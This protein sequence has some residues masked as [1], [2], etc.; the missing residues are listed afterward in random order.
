VALFAKSESPRGRE[1]FA[2]MGETVKC[3][4]CGR[5]YPLNATLLGRI[6]QCR[7]CGQAFRI[8]P[9]VE[10]ETVKPELA[11]PPS[12][13]G[14]PPSVRETPSQRRG[15]PSHPGSKPTDQHA[16]KVEI[17]H[18][19][20]DEEEDEE[21]PSSVPVPSLIYADI[22]ALQSNWEAAVRQLNFRRPEDVANFLA[23]H[24]LMLAVI[25]V[26]FLSLII[27]TQLSEGV[28]GLV[29][30]VMG[31]A[32]APF[33]LLPVPQ[34]NES[35]SGFYVAFVAL[36]WMAVVLL[37]RA[38]HGELLPVM[39]GLSPPTVLSVYAILIAGILAAA[40]GIVGVSLLFR[41]FGFFQ[42]GAWLYMIS[43]VLLPLIWSSCPQSLKDSVSLDAWIHGSFANGEA[44][45]NFGPGV[46]PLAGNPQ[47][48]GLVKHHG[49]N[50][51]VT[52]ELDGFPAD[53]AEAVL[54]HLRN[55][56]KCEGFV[57][58]PSDRGT[59]IVLAPW[60]Q[61][62]SLAAK[63]DFGTVT[64]ID[65][66]LRILSI[67][68][69]LAKLNASLKP[70]N[71][72]TATTTTPSEVASTQQNA[73][74]QGA[75]P[76]RQHEPSKQTQPQEQPKETTQTLLALLATT[77]GPNRL[78]ILDT[79]DVVGGDQIV[80]TLIDLLKDKDP[81]FR[82]KV[83]DILVR[84]GDP[85][86]IEPMVRLLGQPDSG[87]DEALVRMGA[88]AELGI[89]ALLTELDAAASVRACQVLGRIGS[90]RSLSPLKQLS[91]HSNPVVSVAA[92]DAIQAIGRRTS[93]REPTAPV[94]PSEKAKPSSPASDHLP[95][96]VKPPEVSPPKP[97]MVVGKGP[98]S[99]ALAALRSG[100]AERKEAGQRLRQM[101]PDKT[102]S[103]E[104]ADALVRA[105]GETRDA[106]TRV[107][108]IQALA[109][110]YTPETL[111]VL[112][113]GLRDEN[114][115]VRHKTV[116]ALGTVRDEQ[117]IRI[118]AESLGDAN[119]SMLAAQALNAIGPVA[120]KTVLKYAE[121]PNPQLRLQA[122]RV[123]GQIG[124]EKSITTLTRI[125]RTNDAMLRWAVD[126]ATR[127]I[128]ERR[129]DRGDS[130]AGKQPGEAKDPE[131]PDMRKV[132]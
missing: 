10:A 8:N 68:A 32:L 47:M 39:D 62:Q 77:Q 55:Q 99:E 127:S 88:A 22:S 105:L 5:E 132:E 102:R 63:I 119:L 113:E 103:K 69:D 81:E 117:V 93:H 1:G 30:F 2:P 130:A 52:L 17:N 74:M 118:L 92:A 56:T 104:V 29:L 40:G 75:D 57:A 125:A 64:K 27:F 120:E 116:E 91:R 49:V 33:G 82:K 114:L 21:D 15:V 111:P 87:V 123:L 108:L 94:Q 131:G 83:V 51:V 59:T 79:L 115:F 34:A 97:S 60:G 89:L 121:H 7:T 66:E 37:L 6:V 31:L 38:I 129:S 44:V 24:K 46:H 101:T 26:A 98:L 128:R 35:R 70:A 73:D 107:S 36:V 86:A 9:V 84:R 110:W 100:D 16:D 12:P 54:T 19:L 13:Q 67:K 124:S 11:T 4:G 95:V 126:D 106:E 50:R 3:P 109:A 80:P 78:A 53:R 18:D 61:P 76:Q 42:A 112:L 20:L 14:P 25:S 28:Y 71:T 58:P 23:G 43:F 122:V 85:R 45:V 65:S 90:D 48:M 96:P 41:R 72:N